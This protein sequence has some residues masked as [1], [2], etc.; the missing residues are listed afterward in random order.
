MHNIEN[1]KWLGVAISVYE[2]MK[3]IKIRKDCV[4]WNI[5]RVPLRLSSD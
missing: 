2:L 3:N 4:A 1:L 5:A